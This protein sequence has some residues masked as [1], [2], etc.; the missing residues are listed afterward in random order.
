MTNNTLRK[1]AYHKKYDQVENKWF[2]L[3]K[4]KRWQFH[5]RNFVNFPFN[6]VDPIHPYINSELNVSFK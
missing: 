4:L 3:E 1:Q 2:Q 5:I 6:W